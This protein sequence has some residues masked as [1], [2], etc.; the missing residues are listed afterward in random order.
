[1][2][3]PANCQT[4]GAEQGS[5][6][7]KEQACQTDS[8]ICYLLNTKGA[9]HSRV[10]NKLA[11]R[12]SSPSYAVE[13]FVSEGVDKIGKKLPGSCIVKD[14]KLLVLCGLLECL[15]LLCLQCTGKMLHITLW[16]EAITVPTQ[17]T[18]AHSPSV[19][20]QDKSSFSSHQ[21]LRSW[22]TPVKGDC[23]TSKCTNQPR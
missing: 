9:W 4:A 7:K 17:M 22:R 21:C 20:S 12:L 15:L 11:A 19:C 5:G 2:I 1:M 16:T 18:P 8:P 10:G 13:S 14:C 3:L 23:K 6:E